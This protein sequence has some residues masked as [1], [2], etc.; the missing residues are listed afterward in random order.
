LI[1]R[2]SLKMFN[3]EVEASLRGLKAAVPPLTRLLAVKPIS[4]RASGETIT[5][6]C[7]ALMNHCRNLTLNDLTNNHLTTIYSLGE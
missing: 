5:H 1:V 3:I 4:R 6:P 2:E 7:P